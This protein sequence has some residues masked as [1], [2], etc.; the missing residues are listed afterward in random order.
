MQNFGL[1]NKEHYGMLWY[2][3][4]W[5]IGNIKSTINT[6]FTQDIWILNSTMTDDLLLNQFAL[7][8]RSAINNRT[9]G[10]YVSLLF[11]NSSVF[12]S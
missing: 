8:S 2:F 10:L 1:A 7:K 12:S 6:K 3:L 9:T 5:S 4:E 11:T